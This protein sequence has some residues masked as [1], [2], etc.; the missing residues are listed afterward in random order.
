MPKRIV[1]TIAAFLLLC[2]L[3]L[4]AY[5]HEVPDVNRKGSITF[6]MDWEGKKLTNG[7]LTLYRVGDV[8][9][10]DGNY[11]FTIVKELQESGL[12]LD[13][14]TKKDLAQNLADQ[15]AKSKLSKLTADI[16]D[17][18]AVFTDLPAGLY[19][20]TQTESQATKGFAPIAPFLISMPKNENGSYVYEITADPKVPL[21]T[22]PPE[23]TKPAPKPSG[24]LPQTGQMNWPVPVLAVAGMVLFVIGWMLCFG[25][26]E[27][28]ES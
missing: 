9:E 15:A 26:K 27:R 22:A 16:K 13:D 6:T 19:V 1:S 14:L 4:P 23:P 3:C 2:S 20:V 25:K 8:S 11:F 10:N 7:S 5:A 18:K 12:S 21:E 24:K 28:H 17:G